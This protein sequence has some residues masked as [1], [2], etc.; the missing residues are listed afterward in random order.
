MGVRRVAAER[1]LR[2][3]DEAR[4]PYN[5]MQRQTQV[6]VGHAL[7]V[8]EGLSPAM[9]AVMAGRV[10]ANARTRGVL[11]GLG[12]A[13]MGKQYASVAKKVRLSHDE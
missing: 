1:G 7:A 13:I 4:G 3:S 8:L 6:R 10:F 2:A 9:R 5:R 12:R 11:C